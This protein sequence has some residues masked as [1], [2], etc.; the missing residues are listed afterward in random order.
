[1][2]DALGRTVRTQNVAVAAAGG[3]QDVSVAVL[4]TGM[5]ILQVQVGTQLWCQ[6]LQV[7]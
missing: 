7:E 5:Y 2:R 1:V 4:P 3:S 6:Q